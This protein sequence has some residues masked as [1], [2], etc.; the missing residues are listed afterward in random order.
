MS[1]VVE[2]LGGLDGIVHERGAT[3]SAGERQLL[4]LARTFV[5]GPRMLVLDEATSNLDLRSEAQIE[6]A[7]DVLL[8]GRTAV[9]IAHR[10]ATARRADRIAVVDGGRIVEI[11]SHRE[12]VA[13]GGRMRRC[14]TC[15]RATPPGPHPHGASIGAAR[16]CD[17]AGHTRAACGRRRCGAGAQRPSG[18]AAVSRG[19]A[20]TMSE[21][22]ARAARERSEQEREK[23]RRTARRHH[24][25]VLSLRGVQRTIDGARLLRDVHWEVR[26]AERWVVLGPNGSGKTTL[27]RIATMW[28]HPSSGTV[29]LLGQR[30]GAH[31]RAAA[32]GQGRVHQ[33]GDRDHA[34]AVADRS[35]RWS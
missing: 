15:G 28:D 12:L 3:L 2:R 17:R 1:E 16:P 32:A 18:R 24:L 5:S 10:L 35:P 22:E 33:R 21:A 11:G 19:S 9:I 7:L 20:E 30:P 6:Q 23:Q 29:E 13:L 4:A 31:R 34:A 27:V 14:S 26:P 25:P 8:R